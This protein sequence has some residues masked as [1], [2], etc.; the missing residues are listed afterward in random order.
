M[1]DTNEVQMWIFGLVMFP[2]SMLS[3]FASSTISFTAWTLCV[4][5]LYAGFRVNLLDTLFLS[6]SVDCVNGLIL[7]W[8]YGRRKKVDYYYGVCFS[9]LCVTSTVVSAAKLLPLLIDVIQDSGI[10]KSGIGYVDFLLAI[11]FAIR[12][13]RAYKL[14]KKKEQDEQQQLLL[15]NHV[16]EED[17]Q[18]SKKRQESSLNETPSSNFGTTNLTDFPNTQNPPHSKSKIWIGW[19]VLMGL[20]TIVAGL[21]SGLI[22][23]GSGM[24]FAL[25][26]MMLLRLDISTANG[27]ASLHVSGMMLSLIGIYVSGLLNEHFE[28]DALGIEEVGPKLAIMLTGSAIG[29]VAGSRYMMTI[30]P[31]KINFVVA[32]VA[33]AVG[34]VAVSLP[35]FG[36]SNGVDF[37]V[38][39]S[40]LLSQ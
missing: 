31:V 2:L 33:L 29:A 5:L 9:L 15:C 4:P 17:P 7:L 12:G 30:S 25:C 20:I 36:P 23:I 34:I 16:E 26:Y 40:K 28:Q 21:L 6:I 24:I 10:F 32:F 19:Y 38:T 13:Y 27:T 37:L 11:I 35:H 1:E 3:G 39:F 8:I 18:A 22:G 14:E